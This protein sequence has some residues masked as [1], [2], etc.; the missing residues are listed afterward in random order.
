MS[1]LNW[2]QQSKVYILVSTFFFGIYTM[3]FGACVYMLTF[4]QRESPLSLRLLLITIVLYVFAT[5]QAMLTFW[6]G[7]VT[8]DISY[9]GSDQSEDAL[10]IHELLLYEISL[11]IADAV[12]ACANVVADGLLIW[13]CY[14]LWNR[15]VAI[16]IIPIIL[17]IAG[18]GCG[19][20]VAVLQIKMYQLGFP[21]PFEAPPGYMQ[22]SNHISTLF[23]V[24]YTLS[25]T[26]NAMMSGFIAFRVWKATQD[27][28]KSRSKY[29]RV[30][31]LVLETGVL[32]SICS[33][34]CAIL[35]GVQDKI[36]TNPI[37]LGYDITSM[38]LQQLSGIFPTI[39]I[40][41]VAL[42]KTSDLRIDYGRNVDHSRGGRLTTIQ[43]AY[44]PARAQEI[45]ATEG[46]STMG[47]HVTSHAVGSEEIEKIQWSRSLHVA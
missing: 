42:G 13:R 34:L 46:T 7:Y 22:L 32:Y 36:I 33:V 24:F 43:F 5:A 26:T 37:I 23:T 14:V 44:P 41:M 15:R 6:G 16:V 39:I 8:T 40:L 9:D 4:H 27:L 47:L 31:Y 21:A 19:F 1:T 3:I 12:M 30:V 28:G 25:G 35:S 18:T 11:A 17:L 38:I 29:L 10:M 45:D 2:N 20:A